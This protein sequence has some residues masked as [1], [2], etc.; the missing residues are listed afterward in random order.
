[1]NFTKKFDVYDEFSKSYNR[2]GFDFNI[3]VT[4]ILVCFFLLW[5]L[6]SRNFDFYGYIPEDV[7]GRYTVDMYPITTYIRWTGTQFITD[8]F[9]MHWVH[10]FIERP[11][12][13]LMKFIQ[14][15]SIVSVSLLA[16]FGRGPKRIFAFLSYLLLIYLWGNIFLLGQEI[17]SISLYFGML[18]VICFCNYEDKPIW[19]IGSLFLAKKNIDAGRTISWFYLILVAYYFASGLRKLTDLSLVEWFKY[20]LIWE[21]EKTMLIAN[22]T[23]LHVPNVFEHILFIDKWGLFL[24][25]LVY[26]SHLF[27]P[28]VF[29][30]RNKVVYFFLFYAAF[31]FKTFGVGI[32]FTGYIV[33]WGCLFHYREWLTREVVK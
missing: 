2:L 13:E 32:S 23:S 3:N 21:I 11:G 29:F 14:N 9:T 12:P 1:M 27:V 18:L 24:P 6:L 25:P 7:F 17:D 5:K 20:D 4:R 19:R 8:I 10:W 22:I 30:K 31:H 28:L 15:M 16:I 33:V 26:L